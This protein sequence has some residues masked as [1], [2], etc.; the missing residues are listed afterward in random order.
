MMIYIWDDIENDYEQLKM[1][2]G[3]YRAQFY[4]VNR[5]SQVEPRLFRAFSQPF[6]LSCFKYTLFH[7]IENKNQHEPNSPHQI[8]I[9]ENILL[10]S[11]D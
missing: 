5:L 8:M 7:I 3:I 6:D 2:T 11:F 4:I 1:S 10:C 9:N